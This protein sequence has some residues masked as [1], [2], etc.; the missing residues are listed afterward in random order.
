[1]GRGTSKVG[2][3]GGS[4]PK[5]VAAITPRE[6]KDTVVNITRSTGNVN[7]AIPVIKQ[8]MFDAPVD[9]YIEFTQSNNTRNIYKKTPSNIWTMTHYSPSNSFQAWSKLATAS[10]IF[11]EIWNDNPFLYG[12][13]RG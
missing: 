4:A 3:G 10:D 8:A 6:F 12:N 11:N 7:Q 2:G 5:V 9:T 13:T 1:M